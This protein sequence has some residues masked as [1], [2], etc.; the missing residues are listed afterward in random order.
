MVIKKVN[1]GWKGESWEEEMELPSDSF[2]MGA[3]PPALRP[4]LGVQF[5]CI[6][7]TREDFLEA[8]KLSG[9]LRNQ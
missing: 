5:Y 7:L 1:D 6:R 9:V 8:N 3:G 4:G 2:V